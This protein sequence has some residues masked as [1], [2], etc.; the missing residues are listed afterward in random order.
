ME[1]GFSTGKKHGYTYIC[2]EC[3]SDYG[4]ASDIENRQKRGIVELLATKDQKQA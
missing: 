4:C 1:S 2:A 3:D